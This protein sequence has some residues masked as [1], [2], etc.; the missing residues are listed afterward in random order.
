MCKQKIDISCITKYGQ[1]CSLQPLPFKIGMTKLRR[2]TQDEL[3]R[4]VL[5]KSFRAVGD[6]QNVKSNRAT[7][8]G[9]TK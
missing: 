2:G 6:N 1:H 5:K 4:G 8:R 9:H 3:H 7:E